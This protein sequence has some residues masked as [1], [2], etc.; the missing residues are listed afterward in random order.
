MSTITEPAGAWRHDELRTASGLLA[1]AALPQSPRREPLLLIH[2]IA[3][4]AWYWE[5]Y[6]RYFAERGW[7]TYAVELRGRAGSRPAA[8][9][10]RVS[11]AEYVDD[12]REMAAALGRPAVIGHSMG[13]LLAQMLAEADLVAA[14]VLLS[15]ML[16][17]NSS[18]FLSSSSAFLRSVILMCETTAPP[19]PPCSAL[20]CIRNQRSSFGE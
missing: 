19:C 9:P 18:L 15:T 11:L 13:G 5:H 14:T 12:A 16:R 1:R 3:G 4:G 6:L 17:L 8:E 7:P 20:T 2:G 10:G